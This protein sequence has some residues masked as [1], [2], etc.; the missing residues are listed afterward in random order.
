MSI[1]TRSTSE[2]NEIDN[3]EN[4]DGKSTGTRQNSKINKLLYKM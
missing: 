2:L 3:E 1:L 4:H